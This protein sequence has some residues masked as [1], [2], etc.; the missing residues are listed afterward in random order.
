MTDSPPTKHLTTREAIR[1]RPGMYL[2][3]SG[4]GALQQM[5][6]ELVSNAIDQYLRGMAKQLAVTVRDD[7]GIEVSDDGPGMPFDEPSPGV[8]DSRASFHLLELHRTPRVDEAAPHIHIHVRP[9]V[10]IAVVNH[11]SLRLRCRSWRNGQ[12]WEQSFTAGIADSAPR[13]IETGNGRGTTV[14]FYPDPDIVGAHTLDPGVLRASL[15]K[16]VHLFG[17]LEV[18]CGDERFHASNGLMDYLSCVDSQVSW[19]AYNWRGRP[20]FHWRGRHGDFYIDVAATGFSERDGRPCDWHSWVN[21]VAS[22]LH[23]SHVEAF[24]ALLQRHGWS[25]AT[26]LLHVTAYDPRYANPTRDKLS[27][28]AVGAAVE[29]ALATRLGDYCRAHRIGVHA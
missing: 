13:I 23:G 2:G 10:G 29:A 3:D 25:P 6:E 14:L 12:R 22:P 21:G 5:I 16:A 28:P 15:W 9:G 26:V 1:K 4:Q 8:H 24:A 18:R 7:R 17:G 20:P 27:T 19:C 11:A